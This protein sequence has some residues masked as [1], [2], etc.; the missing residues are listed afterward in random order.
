M[1]N[2][3]FITLSVSDGSDMEA[4][5]AFPETAAPCAAIILLQEAFGVNN[6]IRKVAKQL[7]QEGYAVMA[8]DLYHR[9]AK[10]LEI[11]YNDFASALPHYQAIKKEGLTADFQA[12]YAWLQTQEN[13]L[14]TKIGAIGFCLGGR[15][16]FIANTVLPLAAAVSYY[17]GGLDALAGEAVHMQAPHLFVWGGLDTQL[18]QEKINKIID[19]VRAAGKEYTNMV[20]SYAG[21]GF[22]C[23]ER[24]S[25][26]PMAAKE[27][28]VTTLA[29]F[30][31]RLK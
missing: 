24:S 14:S 16:A 26:H 15:V 21:H 3:S 17:G 22:H 12:T 5:V 10:R 30:A 25:Y 9:T 20:I 8:P 28:W 27:A 13:I 1:K 4:Y 31:N 2:Y 29:F 18:P 11:N 23:D 19:G 7:C 6:H